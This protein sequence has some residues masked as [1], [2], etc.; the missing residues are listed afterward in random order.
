MVQYRVGNLVVGTVRVSSTKTVFYHH[1]V[2]HDINGILTNIFLSSQLLEMS[3][4]EKWKLVAKIL[5][6][7]F[8]YNV[9][10][11]LSI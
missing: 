4:I 6:I 1:N 9:Q 8:K 7:L 5:D 2:Q 11:L 10:V 3:F